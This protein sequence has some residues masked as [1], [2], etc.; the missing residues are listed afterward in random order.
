MLETPPPVRRRSP[1]MLCASV[2]FVLTLVGVPRLGDPRSRQEE[3]ARLALRMAQGEI[4]AAVDA[5]ERRHG[6][7]PGLRRG[8]PLGAPRNGKLA[9]AQLAPWLPQGVPVHPLNGGANVRFARPGQ[10]PDSVAGAG[11]VVD[12]RTGVV[13]SGRVESAGARFER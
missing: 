4:A 5:Y 11:W 1:A 12:P 2:V 13:H 3:R 7:L 9:A 6:Q 8:A 10:S